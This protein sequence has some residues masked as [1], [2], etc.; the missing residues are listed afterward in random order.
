MNPGADPACPA[1]GL[2]LWSTRQGGGVLGEEISE[3]EGNITALDGA[4]VRHKEVMS[5]TRVEL[6]VVVGPQTTAPETGTLAFAF[7]SLFGAQ[8]PM[9]EAIVQLVDWIDKNRSEW[10]SIME[11]AEA[12]TRFAYDMSW[13]VGRYLN[14]LPIDKTILLCIDLVLPT[15]WVNFPDMFCATSERVAD[16]ANGYIL[17]PTSAF[18][19]YPPTANQYSTAPAPTASSARL[20]CTEVYMDDL[21]SSTQG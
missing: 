14:A 10:G 3:T 2:S 12:T 18:L 9:V 7:H 8:C 11:D 21:L 6:A 19:I 16:M 5:A 15:G 13:V 1:G 17:D 20:Q 4:N